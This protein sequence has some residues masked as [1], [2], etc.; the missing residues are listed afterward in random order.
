MEENVLP[1]MN[2]Q[3]ES[4]TTGGKSFSWPTEAEER[5]PRLQWKIRGPKI[6]MIGRQL[7][8]Q[9]PDMSLIFEESYQNDECNI[10]IDLPFQED[11]PPNIQPLSI[12][13]ELDHE[14]LFGIM[15]FVKNRSGRN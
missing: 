15:F 12:A 4:L 11:Q 6:D 7:G 3:Q 10:V 8:K 1:M 2:L 14:N 5:K 9:K 13:P